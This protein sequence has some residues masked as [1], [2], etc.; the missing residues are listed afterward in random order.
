MTE[1]NV[2]R[3]AQGM[4]EGHADRRTKEMTEGHA[5]RRAQGVTGEYVDRR[6]QGGTGGHVD[7]R[8]EE[9]AKEKI[10]GILGGMGPEATVE[11]MTRII[12]RTPA[13]RDSDH[14]RCVVDQNAKVPN[15]IRSIAGQIPSAG[16]VLAD[17]AQRLERY[18]V[19]FLCMPCNTA[20][21]Y[22]PDIRKAT[23]LPFIDMITCTTEEVLKHYPNEKK[24]AIASTVPTRD[25]LLYKDHFAEVGIEAVHPSAAIQE[26]LLGIIS[27][28]KAGDMSLEI[29]N[30]LRDIMDEMREGDLRVVVIACTEL[31]V[32]CPHGEGIV[33]ALDCLVDEILRRA[34]GIEV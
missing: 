13:G 16:V 31:S 30:E 24:V 32:V 1:D 29:R 22:L 21:Y 7:R 5:D 2:D 3:R 11:L 6:A 33:D 14:I 17:M 28:V 4:T 15:R 20:H 25:T 18:G 27:S 19:D 34:K 23:T 10:V 26:K 12:N 9:M 8:A